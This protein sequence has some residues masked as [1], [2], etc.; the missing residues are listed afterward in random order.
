MNDS[1][2]KQVNGQG[3]LPSSFMPAA[4]PACGR[5]DLNVHAE[6]IRNSIVAMLVN[7]ATMIDGNNQTETTKDNPSVLT[8][9]M[10]Y[11]ASMATAVNALESEYGILTCDICHEMM[12]DF[13]P[14]D[15]YQRDASM[16]DN[17]RPPDFFPESLTH[18]TAALQQPL[19]LYSLKDADYRQ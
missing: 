11:N 15:V 17:L 3:W 2:L 12:L 5:K 7:K 6:S 16:F 18:N 19:T 4:C 9:Q 1:L 10:L 8:R 14:M 13:E